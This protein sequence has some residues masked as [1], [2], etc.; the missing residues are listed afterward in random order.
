MGPRVATRPGTLCWSTA[1]VCARVLPSLASLFS[2]A[3]VLKSASSATCRGRRA[4]GGGASAST[5]P[6][7]PIDATSSC[8][9]PA[10]STLLYHP[11][12][13]SLFLPLLPSALPA[14][15]HQSQALEKTQRELLCQR[16]CS[17]AKTVQRGKMELTPT[18]GDWP[19]LP[20]ST[21]T[22]SS[23]PAPEAV[24]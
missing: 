2:R 15:P 23:I 10:Q 1:R 21:L 20:A 17:R 19:T 24:T 11:L 6:P 7:D 9:L 3:G 22:T 13:D 12:P 18:D 4:A 5:G 14:P 16:N 8:H